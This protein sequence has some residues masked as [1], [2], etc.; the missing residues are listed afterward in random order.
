M[1]PTDFEVQDLQ[2]GTSGA[3]DEE[4]SGNRVVLYIE[5]PEFRTMFLGFDTN[6]EVD[7]RIETISDAEEDSA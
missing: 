5:E 4:R 2:Y 3:T 1:R 7:A 6:R